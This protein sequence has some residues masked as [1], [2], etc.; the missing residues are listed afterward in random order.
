MLLSSKDI[1]NSSKLTVKTFIMLWKSSISNKWC[2]LELSIHYSFLRLLRHDFKNK[3]HFVK[4]LHTVCT[5]THTSSRTPQIFCKMKDFIQN[6]TIIWRN[7]VSVLNNES[8]SVWTTYTLLCTILN[9]SIFLMI[10]SGFDFYLHFFEILL[11][12]MNWPNT[13]HETSV[14]HWWKY[15]FLTT[16]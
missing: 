13:I 15:L 12:N 8:D 9:I 10:Q 6:F 5:S 2:S 14:A 4:T 1:L 16:L 11:K 3:A 7:P